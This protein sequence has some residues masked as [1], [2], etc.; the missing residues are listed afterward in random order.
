[1]K[2]PVKKLLLALASTA[3]LAALGEAIARRY[4]PD[5]GVTIFRTSAVPGLSAEMRPGF[6][7]LYK[8]FQVQVNSE[9]FRGP[10][11]PAKEEGVPRIVLVGDSMTFGSSI[12][13]PDTLGVKL[14]Q[15]LARSGQR[16]QVLNLAVVGY[17]A[18]NIAALVEHRALAFEPD[19]VVYVFYA[20]DTLP[21][22][23][24]GEIP[25]DATI[26]PLAGYPAHSALLQWTY[27]WVKEAVMHLGWSLAH[28][29]P[30]A[31]RGEYMGGGGARVREA[32]ARVQAACR[33]HGARL[34]VASYPHLIQPRFNS[35]RPIE[36]LAAADAR[37]L[38]IEWIDLAEA[39]GPRT[40]VRDLWASVFDHHPNGKANGMAAEILART[41]QP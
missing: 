8:G 31:S 23:D 28:R 29:T 37:A 32:L 41:L 34:I 18:L 39:F 35:F 40:H 2:P 38:G 12:D 21:P 33:E 30:D 3:A 19:V 24:W 22:D 15:A 26:D 5:C 36:E 13:W 6:R 17:C 11:F 16:A 25:P 7:G 9:G 27:V 20:N 10:E 1:M 14:E 4:V